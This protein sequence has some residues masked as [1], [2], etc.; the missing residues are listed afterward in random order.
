MIRPMGHGGGPPPFLLFPRR[1]KKKRC[2]LIH[3]RSEQMRL[4]WEGETAAPPL[5][6]Q[7]KGGGEKLRGLFLGGEGRRAGTLARCARQR[8]KQSY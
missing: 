4:R 5:M 6:G 3:T 8:E 2:E 7:E 1:K